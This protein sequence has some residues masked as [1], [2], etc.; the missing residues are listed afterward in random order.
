[1]LTYCKTAVVMLFIC[2]D[3]QL[4]TTKYS[5]SDLLNLP[6]HLFWLN[7]QYLYTWSI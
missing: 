1:M 5:R 2:Q 4:T 3:V 6:L 7:S